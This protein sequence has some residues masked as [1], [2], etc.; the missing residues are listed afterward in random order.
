MKRVQVDNRRRGR[1]C[2]KQHAEDFLLWIACKRG[3]LQ[4]SKSL[5]LNFV[6]VFLLFLLT[7]VT[8]E[9]GCQ[10]LNG[11]VCLVCSK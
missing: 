1:V 9:R 8:S 3:L 5:L 4:E 2:C 6:V 7:L 10:A 11:F